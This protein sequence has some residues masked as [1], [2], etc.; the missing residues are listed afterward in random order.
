MAGGFK[1]SSI[2]SPNSYQSTQSQSSN[3]QPALTPSTPAGLDGL[4][5]SQDAVDN[6][7]TPGVN[8]A[9]A[10]PFNAGGN[11]GGSGDLSQIM[12]ELANLVEMLVQALEKG[13]SPQSSPQAPTAAPAGTGTEQGQ[14]AGAN[15]GNPSPTG[16]SGGANASGTNGAAGATGTITGATGGS[17]TPQQGTEGLYPNGSP[18]ESDVQQGQTGDCGFAAQL[19]GLAARDPSQITNMISSDGGG[20]YNVKLY[21]NGQPTTVNVSA[22]ELNTTS[23]THS[24]SGQADWATVVE[25]AATKM[26]GDLTSIMPGDAQAM[27]T[28]KQGQQSQM[29]DLGGDQGVESKIANTLSSGGLIDAFGNGGTTSNGEQII[30]NHDYAVVG[31]NGN[32]VTVQN[33]WGSL[34]PNHTNGQ[35]TMSIQDFEKMFG[36]VDSQ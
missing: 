7:A 12:G 3:T 17:G 11:G 10:N 26:H 20:G 22:N 30:G 9:T 21:N 36:Y 14:G 15:G 5:L 34:D 8:G 33:P 1:M 32:Q 29:G 2:Q 31:L 16:G 28:G 35:E 6:S 24:N 19:A 25:A 27:L 13:S 18:K 23:Q 4:P